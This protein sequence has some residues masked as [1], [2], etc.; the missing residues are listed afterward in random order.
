MVSL[1]VIII[2]K[3]MLMIILFIESKLLNI[4]FD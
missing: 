4:Q 1:E 3:N 2:G